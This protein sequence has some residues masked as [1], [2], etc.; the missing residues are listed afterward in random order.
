MTNQN[1][2]RIIGDVTAIKEQRGK[3]YSTEPK[4]IVPTEV[5][6]SVAYL[7]AVRG[8]EGLSIEKK[9]DE[10]RDLINYCVFIIDRLEQQ[11]SDMIDSSD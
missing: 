10:Y 9:L 5:L 7:K 8:Y 1:Y 11:Q 4:D 6:E 2:E 3:M